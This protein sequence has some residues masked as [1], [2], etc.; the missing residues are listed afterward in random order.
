[1]AVLVICF[2]HADADASRI[3][4]SLPE[5]LEDGARSTGQQLDH[6]HYLHL[7]LDHANKCPAYTRPFEIARCR[8]VAWLQRSP[9][10]A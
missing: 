5:S 2:A 1:M 7:R 6:L 10:R 8:N 9:E 4:I 3:G